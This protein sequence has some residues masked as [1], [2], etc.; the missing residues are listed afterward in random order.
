AADLISIAD[1]HGIVGQ[2]FD[3]KVLAELPV[4]QVRSLQPLLPIA[5]RFNLIHED[6]SLLTAMPRQVSLTVSLD[7][8]PPD[9]AATRR[10]TFP[11]PGVDRAP[12]PHDVARK[13]NVYR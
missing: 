1:T 12:L 3:R 10:R 11:P 4:N 9:A 13:S 6:G 7:V 2:P 8:E 5:V